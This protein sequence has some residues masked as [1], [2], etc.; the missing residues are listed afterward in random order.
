VNNVGNVD[1]DLDVFQEELEDFYYD[2]RRAATA[3][4]FGFTKFPSNEGCELSKEEIAHVAQLRACYKALKVT[5]RACMTGMQQHPAAAEAF[6][7][8]I[9]A[10]LFATRGLLNARRDLVFKG[11]MGDGFKMWRIL[12]AGG[13]REDDRRLALEAMNVASTANLAKLVSGA[14]RGAQGAAR[15]NSGFGGSSSGG[16]GK[17]RGGQRHFNNNNKPNNGRGAGPSASAN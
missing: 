4:L 7:D 16:N 2:A 13:I 6:A 9:Y 17:R 3:P 10:A 8:A 14:S 11:L 12:S 15:N 5:V 1:I